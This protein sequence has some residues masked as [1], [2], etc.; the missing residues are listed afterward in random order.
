M[1]WPVGFSNAE[2]NQAGG[3]ASPEAIPTPAD[4]IIR[5]SSVPARVVAVLRFETPAT[6]P[7]VKYYAGRLLELLQADRLVPTAASAEEYVL[8]QYDAIFSI[9]TR[10]NEVWAVLETHDW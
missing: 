1:V 10:R 4:D 6:A 9:G 8:C 7:V 2:L 3:A 5:R